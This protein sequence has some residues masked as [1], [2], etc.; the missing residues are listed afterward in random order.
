MN[1]KDAFIRSLA[2]WVAAANSLEQEPLLTDEE[3]NAIQ[4]AVLTSVS[5]G[6][7]GHMDPYALAASLKDAF[8]FLAASRSSTG[9]TA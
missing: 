2:G 4:Q 6:A 5:S 3:I 1:E 9:R 7:H 8:S